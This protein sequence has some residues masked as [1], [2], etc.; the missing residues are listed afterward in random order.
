MKV[1]HYCHLI[2]FFIRFIGLAFIEMKREATINRKTN[3]WVKSSIVAYLFYGVNP[4]NFDTYY[5]ITK[6]TRFVKLWEYGVD[7]RPYN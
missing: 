6:H 1:F 4:F 3:E 5:L 2:N 7:D